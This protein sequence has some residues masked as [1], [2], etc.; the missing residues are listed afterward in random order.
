MRLL[1]AVAVGVVLFIVSILAFFAALNFVLC[2]ADEIDEPL[3]EE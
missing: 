3:D 1:I 2:L